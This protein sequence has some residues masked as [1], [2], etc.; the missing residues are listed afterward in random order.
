MQLRAICFDLDDTLWP[1]GPTIQKAEQTLY[2]WLAEN[3]PRIVEQFSIQ[4]LANFRHH[5]LE[6]YPQLHHDLA[7]LRKLSLA[8]VALHV[9]YDDCLVDPAFEVFQ[10]AR[11]QVVLFHDVLPVLE[12][13]HEQYIL[14]A[15]TNGTADVQRLGLG[16]LFDL[17][18]SAKDVGAAK[19]HPALFLA[20]CEFV[21][22][23]PSQLMHV[24]D[25]LEKDV[26]G[27]LAVGMH[28]VWI[29]RHPQHILNILPGR[30]ITSLLELEKVLG[31]VIN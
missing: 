17:A 25:D 27:A 21:H 20:A 6:E 31:R 12:K 9:G 7:S 23:P 29:N 26:Y 13:L 11:H 10:Q 18:L 24:G 1:L 14:C 28:A 4:Q 5:L 2:H 3:Y 15:L 30:V 22:A 8:R 19:P 16:H